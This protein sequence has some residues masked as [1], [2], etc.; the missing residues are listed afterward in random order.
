[1]HDK[2]VTK[3]QSLFLMWV[4][5]DC[6]LTKSRK[7]KE[8]LFSE[9]QTSIILTFVLVKS[10]QASDEHAT[11]DFSSSAANCSHK[12][13][14]SLS[15]SP[16]V[17]IWDYQ[18]KT[19][20]TAANIRLC[21]RCW[22]DSGA[23][24]PEL[25]T[26]GARSH[27]SRA[28]NDDRSCCQKPAEDRQH[29]CGLSR[30]CRCWCCPALAQ[31]KCWGTQRQTAGYL[32]RSDGDGTSTAGP[33]ELWWP[34]GRSR[35]QRQ[36]TWTVLAQSHRCHW[37]LFVLFLSLRL[38]WE[39]EKGRRNRDERVNQDTRHRDI[40]TISLSLCPGTSWSVCVN[41]KTSVK[42]GHQRICSNL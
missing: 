42:A 25:C 6:L 41:M 11:C 36:P 14:C 33:A 31:P 20:I 24:S 10:T 2:D 7:R 38:S 29:R 22:W 28:H 30:C 13:V 35:S 18:Q 9:T 32:G 3:H 40:K 19:G 8:N 4:L 26:Q 12:S 34:E 17:Q 23:L 15:V 16:T 21:S 37:G 5:S 27:C 1:M 39:T